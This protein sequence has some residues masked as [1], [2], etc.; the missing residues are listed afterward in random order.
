L[1][2]RVRDNHEAKFAKLESLLEIILSDLKLDITPTHW[3]NWMQVALKYTKRRDLAGVR[4]FL[5]A[6]G[7]MGSFNDWAP[8]SAD[9][10]K[11]DTEALGLARSLSSKN[12][13]DSGIDLIIEHRATLKR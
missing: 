3:T 10:W 13:F 4:F 12:L 8:L 7:G 5:S 1:E 9:G 6:H 2:K 11:T